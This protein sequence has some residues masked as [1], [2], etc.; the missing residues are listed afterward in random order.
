MAF[1]FR[2]RSHDVPGL[3]T[4]STADISFM[5]LILFLVTTSMDIDKG[6]QRQLPPQK[7]TTEQVVESEVPEG[8]MLTIGISSSDSLTIDGVPAT[9]GDIPGR[10]AA[11]VAHAGRQHIVKLSVS[12]KSSYD[13][14]YHVQNTIVNTYAALRERQARKLYHQRLADCSAEQQERVARMIPQRILE[15]YGDGE[16]PKK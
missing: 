9:T 13:A 8:T 16:A 10:L 1:L 15:T 6:I 3:N 5:L 11:L 2:N 4:T 14:F 7:P 12:R